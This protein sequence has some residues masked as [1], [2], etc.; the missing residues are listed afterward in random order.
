LKAV[1][2]LFGVKQFCFAWCRVPFKLGPHH[3]YGTS[4]VI[5]KKPSR[6]TLPFLFLLS[7]LNL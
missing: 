1:V 4:H 3:G 6:L 2:I 7:F 5:P